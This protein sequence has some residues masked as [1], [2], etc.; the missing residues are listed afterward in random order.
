MRDRPR[1]LSHGEEPGKC[2]KLLCECA[3]GLGHVVCH[4]CRKNNCVPRQPFLVSRVCITLPHLLLEIA[5]FTSLLQLHLYMHLYIHIVYHS[6]SFVLDAY[7]ASLPIYVVG[8]VLVAL[9]DQRL[10]EKPGCGNEN[11]T[12]AKQA[13]GQTRNWDFRE[14][15]G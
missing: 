6:C 12:L 11:D 7:L 3:T 10:S 9:L 13:G 15:L 4:C 14:E 8:A 1:G 5:A 2:L